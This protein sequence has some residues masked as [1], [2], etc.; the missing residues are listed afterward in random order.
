LL[1]LNLIISPVSLIVAGLGTWVLALFYALGAGLSYGT[2][3][4]SRYACGS[5]L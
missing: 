3:R 5:L 4:Q 2:D 1:F